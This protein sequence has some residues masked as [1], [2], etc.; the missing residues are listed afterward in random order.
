MRLAA[1]VAGS[2]DS[3]R[4]FFQGAD[5]GFA[6]VSVVSGKLCGGLPALVVMLPQGI[7]WPLYVLPPLKYGLQSLHSYC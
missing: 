7:G 3:I 4:A 5:D 6:A 1:F 2:D